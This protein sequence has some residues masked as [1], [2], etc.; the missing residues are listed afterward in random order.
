PRSAP[1]CFSTEDEESPDGADGDAADGEAV[2]VSE[3]IPYSAV[4][5]ILCDGSIV[6]AFL[7]TGGALVAL[8]TEDRLFNRAQR[9]GMIARDGP[10]CG[11]PGCEI[12]ATGCEAHHIIEYS[13]GGPTTIDNGALYC[14]F[15]HRMIDTGVFSVEMVDGRPKVTF[16]DWLKRKPYFH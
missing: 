6:P 11:I 10:T 9:M 8:G 16:P 2:G 4:R 7:D 1:R 15:H 3:P 13:K 5:Q 14:W 12:P